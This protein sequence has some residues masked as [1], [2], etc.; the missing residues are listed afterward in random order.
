MR[1]EVSRLATRG[2]TNRNDRG[3]A[4]QRRAR[5]AWLVD[6]FG[7]RVTL[8]DGSEVGLVCCYRCEVVLLEH[9]DPSAP[10]QGVTADRIVPGALGGRYVRGN[11]RPACGPCNSETGGHL[12][13]ALAAV[14]AL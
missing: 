4:A 6:V 9:D 14:A 3:S 1:G 11:L 10:G 2:T 8:P 13:V 5:R 12:R 7:W